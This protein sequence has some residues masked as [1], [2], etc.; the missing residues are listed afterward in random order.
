MSR[1]RTIRSD[2]REIRPAHVARW[3][4]NSLTEGWYFSGDESSRDRVRLLLHNYNANIVANWIGGTFFTGLLLLMDAD[5]GFIGMTTMISTAANMLQMFTPLLLERFPRRKV[6]LLTL[7]A[8]MMA[9]NILFIGLIPLFPMQQQARLA[10][11]AA[12]ILAVNVINALISSGISIWHVQ[13]LRPNVRN[14]FF[15]LVSMTVGAVVA[16]INLV[17]SGIVDLF[18]LQGME[19]EGLMLLRV[20]SAILMG[21][22]IV[23]I[24]K[25]REYPYHTSEKK[26][27]LSDVFIKPL[28]E[29]LYLRT[30][31]VAFLWNFT[32]NIPGSYYTVYL[33]DNLG[34]SY[35]FI[36]LINFINVPVV[37]LATPLWNKL[38]WR[39]SRF[40][41]LYMSMSIFLLHYVLLSFVTNG[42]LWLYAVAMILN[43]LLAAGIN[44]SFMGIPYVNM[45]AESQTSHLGFYSTMANVAAF[46]G[47]TLGRQFILGTEG[48]T[49]NLLG[50][51]MGNKQYI[52]LLTAALML[53]AVLGIWRIQK[54]TVETDSDI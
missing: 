16:I 28:R 15:S 29:K 44:L 4:K 8:I 12:T 50:F 7:Y 43:F 40:A 41:I 13:S 32:A 36:M 33:L 3:L 9:L 24:A 2:L 39:K 6:L 22:N 52:L 19:Y 46:L 38:L 34:L 25:I 18:R 42:A 14:A 37:L 51:S 53:L 21:I 49:L 35:T 47:V 20:L 1:W 48:Y 10:L 26:F 27:T 17:G 23:T 30:V 45:P 5:D 54:K 11:V 31:W